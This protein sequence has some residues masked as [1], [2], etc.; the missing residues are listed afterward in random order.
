MAG[1][2]QT[3]K[4]KQRKQVR[5]QPEKEPYSDATD[6]EK[7]TYQYDLCINIPCY[8]FVT[9]P[10][11]EREPVTLT[12]QSTSHLRP[13]AMEFYPDERCDPLENQFQDLYQEHMKTHRFVPS[14][15]SM[16]PDKDEDRL[17]KEK[18]QSEM[19]EMEEEEEGNVRKM[20]RQGKP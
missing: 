16:M 13:M 20:Q 19:Q 15:R 14:P 17:R 2:K 6:E 7:H 1:I 12:T 18:K 5:S 3:K 10:Q 4:V 11:T 8:K 9:V